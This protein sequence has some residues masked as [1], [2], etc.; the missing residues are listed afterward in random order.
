MSNQHAGVYM[1]V[2]HDREYHEEG[3]ISTGVKCNIPVIVQ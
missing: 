2:T 1:C 3:I